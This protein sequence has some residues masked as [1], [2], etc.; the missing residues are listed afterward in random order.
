MRTKSTGRWLRRSAASIA[1]LAALGS[2]ASA[3]AALRSYPLPLDKAVTANVGTAHLYLGPAGRLNVPVNALATVNL[4][5]SGSPLFVTAWPALCPFGS[6]GALAE[7]ATN[8]GPASASISL[9]KNGTMLANYPITIPALYTGE[10]G[11]CID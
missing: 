9:T 8:G 4:H 3:Q 7:V 5:V 2:A 1:A 11:A 10:I 6:I